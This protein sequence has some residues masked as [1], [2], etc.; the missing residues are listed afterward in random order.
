M[1]GALT[2]SI[3]NKKG[4]AGTENRIKM[5][6]IYDITGKLMMQRSFADRPARVRL[7][8]SKLISGFYLVTIFDG[9]QSRGYKLMIEK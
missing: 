3:E 1:V 9:E 2:Y 5:V 7:D 8:V 6:S 4:L